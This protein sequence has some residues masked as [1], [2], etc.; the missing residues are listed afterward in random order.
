MFTDPIKNLKQLGLRDDMVV[1]DL[2]AGTGFYSIIAAEMVL[3][4]R[5]YAVEIIKD[6]LET[7]RRKAKDLDLDN[8]ECL[9]GDIEKR[10]GTNLA[11]NIADVVLISNVLSQIEDQDALIA[12]AYR[13]LK[14]G[15]RVL[16]IDWLKSFSEEEKIKQKIISLKKV[17]EIFTK[18][19][20]I[21]NKEI[22]AGLTHYGIIFNK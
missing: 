3:N 8:L 17:K 13:I 18:N 1:V 9:W 11:D 5:V 4:G 14:K 7:I 21:L 10:G 12:E 19:N 15:G 16:V 6:F 22:D 2:G 20:F